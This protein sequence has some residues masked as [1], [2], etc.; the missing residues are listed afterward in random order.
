MNNKVFVGGL[1]WNTDEET[2]KSIFAA[3]GTVTEAKII[4]MPDGRS[5]GFGFVTYEADEQA[6]DAINK[7]NNTEVDERTIRVSTASEEGSK[8]KLF[9]GGLS[10]DTTSESLREVFEE[11]GEVISAKVVTDRE[12]NNRSK[13]FGFI[14]MASDDLAKKAEEVMNG[15]E[16][17]GRDIRVEFVKD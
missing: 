17:D 12:N 11:V 6:A 2:L 7:L 4:R 14:T 13:G 8:A 5:K 3:C 1:S 9:I 15:R 10:W 16:V